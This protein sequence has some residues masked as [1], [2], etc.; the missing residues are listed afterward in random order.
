MAL[1]SFSDLKSE[2]AV[3]LNRE[4]LTTAI[5]TFITL[6]EANINR[7]VRHWRMEKRSEADF[8]GRYTNLPTDWLETLRLTIDTGLEEPLRVIPR[9]EMERKRAK[10]S[11]TAGTPC[12][13]AQVGGQL[14]VYPT[15]SASTQLELLYYG[16]IPALGVSQP[17][18]WLL[19]YAPDVY[20]YGAL[21][22]SAPYLR[23][24]QRVPVW[25][26][27]YE[28]AV[29]DLNAEGKIAQVSGGALVMRQPS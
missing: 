23:D 28:K 19:E 10:G 20:L 2:I 29:A 16:K 3:F 15:P 21:L 18:N 24:D 1:S 14:E 27:F 8:S 11:D 26:S 12:F 9:V 22:H 25:T 5:E 7:D 4:D 13:Y 6:A 17:S